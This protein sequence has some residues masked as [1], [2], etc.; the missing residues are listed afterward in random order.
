MNRVGPAQ[1]M[2]S[3]PRAA[4][5]SPLP[6]VRLVA[7][8]LEPLHLG[9][10]RLND[11]DSRAKAPTTRS[12]SGMSQRNIAYWRLPLPS[13]VMPRCRQRQLVIGLPRTDPKL[14]ITNASATL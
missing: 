14:A 9:A 2:S 7:V 12:A 1:R 13:A 5:K 3:R 4:R 11:A 8:G 10:S 6:R